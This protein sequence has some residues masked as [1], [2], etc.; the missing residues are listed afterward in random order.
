MELFADGNTRSSIMR[1]DINETLEVSRLEL[2]C[3]AS[4]YNDLEAW[5][6]FQR[7]LEGTVLTWLH[8]HPGREIACR[9]QSERHFVA[10]AFE[11]LRQAVV[12]R[13]VTFETLPE[14]LL[15]LRASLCGAILEM[16]RASSRPKA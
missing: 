1:Q 11:Q 2:L 10:Q 7:D 15:Y 16:Q 6:A 9:M 5:A 3:R 8:N 4:T 13:H 12:Q 14:A